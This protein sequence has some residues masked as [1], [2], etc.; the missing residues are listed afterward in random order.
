MVEINGKPLPEGA[1]P[2]TLRIDGEHFAGFGGCNRYMGPIRE[3][4]PGEVAIG[5]LAGTMMACPEPDM[6]L[7]QGFLSV[8]G[9]VSHYAFVAGRGGPRTSRETH[10]GDDSRD[11]GGRAASGTVAEGAAPTGRALP[12]I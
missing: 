5:P 10:R 1:R 8:F 3:M 6:A 12:K 4:A 7:E 11:G 9:K 2:P